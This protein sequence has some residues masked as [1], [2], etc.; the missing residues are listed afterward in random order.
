MFDPTVFDNLKV[1]FENQLYDLDNLDKEITIVSR[2]D[3]ME[4]ATMSREFRL[5]FTLQENAEV[6][7]EICLE[8]SLRDLADEIL[9]EPEKNPGC[10]LRLFFYMTVEEPDTE[11]PEIESILT[12]I[13]TP[14][15][16][17][18][19]TL[20]YTYDKQ[21][22][23]YQNTA[24]VRFDRKVNENQMEDLPNLIDHILDSL[25]ALTTE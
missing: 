16:R 5:G 6:T 20:Q 8:A 25:E 2:H 21:Q 12:Q 15:S 17:P 24:E 22:K 19:Q 14:P 1:A 18:E 7:A 9:E 23:H 11:C 4:M 13:W 3:R 10:T